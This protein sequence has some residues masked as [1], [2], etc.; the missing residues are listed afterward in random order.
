MSLLA[1]LGATV[2]PEYVDRSCFYDIT[3]ELK[4]YTNQSTQI[5]IL[6]DRGVVLDG[7]SCQISISGTRRLANLNTAVDGGYII[8]PITKNNLRPHRP[9]AQENVEEIQAMRAAMEAPGLILMS[10][11]YDVYDEIHLAVTR[12]DPGRGLFA[13]F[14]GCEAR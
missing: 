13:I 4:H 2:P 7:L 10:A 6:F 12:S 5:R 3:R 14:D 1:R 8:A 11:A 9:T